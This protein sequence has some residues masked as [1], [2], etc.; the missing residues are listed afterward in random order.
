[1]SIETPVPLPNYSLTSVAIPGTLDDTNNAFDITAAG[2]YILPLIATS[3]RN[4]TFV[5]IRN[6]SVGS[7]ILTAT[8]PDTISAGYTTLTTGQGVLLIAN[9]SGGSNS[10]LGLIKPQ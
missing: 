7:V 1:M 4:G 3:Y 9:K 8:A 2:T 6:T 5:W 10:W